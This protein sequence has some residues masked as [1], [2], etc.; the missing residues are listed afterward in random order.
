MELTVQIG[1]SQLV[2]AIRKLLPE[3][4][5]SIQSVLEEDT[6]PSKNKPRQFGTLKGLVTYIADDFDAP[7]D[8]FKEYM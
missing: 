5:K 2:Q 3:Q 7:L 6:N 1:F 8:D 4:R